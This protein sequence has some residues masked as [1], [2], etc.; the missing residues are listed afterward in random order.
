MQAVNP[1]ST[2]EDVCPSC[3]RSDALAKVW[4]GPDGES[5]RTCLGLNRDEHPGRKYT[6]N[7]ETRQERQLASPSLFRFWELHKQGKPITIRGIPATFLYERG[8]V[9][10]LRAKDIGDVYGKDGGYFDWATAHELEGRVITSLPFHDGAEV[11]GL[12]LRAF[13]PKTG[14][15]P[16]DHEY[17]RN[18]GQ[19]GIYTPNVKGSN[20]DFVVI[21]EGPWGAIAANYDA[22]EYG[23]HTLVSV[24][25]ASART[26]PKKIQKT[27]DLIYPRVDRFALLDQDPAGISARRYIG[28]VAKLILVTGA[29]EGKDYR[30]L[31][32][33]LRFEA[34]ADAVMRAFKA[35]ETRRDGLVAPD[36]RELD[37]RLSGFLRTEFGLRDRFCERWGANCRYVEAWQKWIIFAGGRWRVSNLAAQNCAQ[38]TIEALMREAEFVEGEIDDVP[39]Q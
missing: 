39:T 28:G 15:G 30:D 38:T 16:S 6:F 25:V 34:L 1:S 36:Q 7:V 23:N 12:Q 3:G 13:D 27:L 33:A 17:I 29:G 26:S 24:A 11:C 35:L 21:H 20:P 22:H 18:I 9:V 5:Y 14:D 32:P 19:D 31:E 2:L 8:Q 10:H 37:V 4:V